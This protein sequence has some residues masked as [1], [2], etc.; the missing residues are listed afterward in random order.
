MFAEPS[1]RLQAWYL[2]N[3]GDLL[4]VCE[5]LLGGGG[6]TAGPLQG[7]LAEAS[8]GFRLMLRELL[9]R[10]RQALEQL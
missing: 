10:Y 5:A 3:R 6:S 2:R 9:P 1:T 8:T 7:N 4:E